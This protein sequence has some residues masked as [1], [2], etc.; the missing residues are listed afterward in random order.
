MLRGVL[1]VSAALA[2]ASPGSGRAATP[3]PALRHVTIMLRGDSTMY[4]THPGQ[5]NGA[6]PDQTPNN[7]PALLQADFDATLPG[8]VTV[9]NRAEPGSWLEEDLDGTGPYTDGTLASELAASPNVTIVITNSEINDYTFSD[10]ADYRK[11]LTAWIATV[12][13]AGKTPWIE[14]PNPTCGVVACARPVPRDVTAFLSA[15]R[16]VARSTGV[17][18]IPMYQ[19]FLAQ[20]GWTHLLQRDGVHPTDKG[21]AVKETQAFG[22]LLS[23]VRSMLSP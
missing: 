18:L 17:R 6:V 1:V 2:L 23:A 22:S 5:W 12:R 4:G 3:A 8:R 21:Y 13:A 19:S 11:N 7:P 20:P 15:M 16:S 10:P 14:E 9:I